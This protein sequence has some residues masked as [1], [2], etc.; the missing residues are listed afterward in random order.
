VDVG[1]QVVTGVHH[2]ARCREFGHD[3]HRPMLVQP[4]HHIKPPFSAWLPWQT[5]RS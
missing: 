2:H 3:R 5:A 1:K 4:L